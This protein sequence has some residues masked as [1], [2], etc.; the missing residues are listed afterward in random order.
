MDATNKGVAMGRES[1]AAD[2]SR[3]KRTHR[4]SGG[5]KAP[6]TASDKTDANPNHRED[7]KRLLAR[8]VAG[9]QTPEKARG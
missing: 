8:S 2:E 9:A 4:R 5:L 6:K 7:F 1:V 3:P